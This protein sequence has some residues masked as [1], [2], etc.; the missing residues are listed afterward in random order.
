MAR[1]SNGNGWSSSARRG[2][3]GDESGATGG[4]VGEGFFGGR[5]GMKKGPHSGPPYYSGP[6]FDPHGSGPMTPSDDGGGSRAHVK[7]DSWDAP[8]GTPSDTPRPHG[9]R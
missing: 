4:P 2:V 9:R 6:R 5:G 3:N 8:C 1:M 7:E